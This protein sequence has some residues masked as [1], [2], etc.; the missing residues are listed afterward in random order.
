MRVLSLLVAACL[1]V[2]AHAVCT[3]DGAYGVRFG[4]KVGLFA[5]RYKEPGLNSPY[6]GAY[7]VKPKQPD[8]R[9]ER[10]L[11]RADNEDKVIFEISALKAL[12]NAS[13]LMPGDEYRA[14]VYP[15]LDGLATEI[16][17]EQGV[18]LQ[19]KSGDFYAY[20]GSD[21]GVQITAILEGGT[22]YAKVQCTNMALNHAMEQRVQKR[23]FECIGDG[24]VYKPECYQGAPK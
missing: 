8:S 1:S 17:S 11:V 2:P 18:A 23:M 9:F 3:A 19:R 12:F 22:A 14:K 21:V 20:Y 6:I 4:E 16:S 13:A 15:A 5:S 10:Y 7:T 24:K